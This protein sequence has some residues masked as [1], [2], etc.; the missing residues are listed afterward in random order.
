LA[1][2]FTGYRWSEIHIPSIPLN[3]VG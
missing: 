3:L 1:A 2:T